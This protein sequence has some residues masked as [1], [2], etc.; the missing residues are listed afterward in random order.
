MHFD[1]VVTGDDVR[2]GKPHPEPYLRAAAE[3]GVDPTRVRR[4]RGLP[5]RRRGRRRPPAASC[6]PCRNIVAIEPAPGRYV[7]DS[8]KDVGV[9]DLGAYVAETPPP[10][11]PPAAATRPPSRVAIGAGGGSSLVGGGVVAAVAAIA[12]ASAVLGG[13]DDAPRRASPAPLDVHAWTP[14]WALDDALPDARRRA[15]TRS[16]RCRRSGSARP[17]STTIEVEPNTPTDAGRAVR[18]PARRARQSRSWPRSSTAPTP[19]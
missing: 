17:A 4:D 1:A 15:P 6:S 2:D 9:D 19:A 5:D 8:L 16:T 11:P 3:L 13:G 10:A 7:V 12:S 14:Y 18:R